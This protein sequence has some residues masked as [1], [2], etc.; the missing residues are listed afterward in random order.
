MARAVLTLA[1][2]LAAGAAAAQTPPALRCRGGG[3]TGR[4]IVATALTSPLY[5]RI[6]GI[7]GAAQSC[8]IKARDGTFEARIGFGDGAEMTVE[9]TPD[10]GVA[11]Y[12][13]TLSGEQRPTAAEAVALLDR[14]AHWAVPPGGCGLSRGAL[15]RGLTAPDAPGMAEGDTC[16]CRATLTRDA[17]GIAGL[18]FSSA[19]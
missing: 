12:A 16:N 14:L 7:Y 4:E 11:A 5:D 13:A 6:S 18:R 17:A 9:A 19:C 8:A 3:E 10:I 1:L 2:A 15:R